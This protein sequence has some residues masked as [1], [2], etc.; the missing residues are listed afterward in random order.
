MAPRLLEL[1]EAFQS[2]L[3]SFDP[4]SVD[5][6]AAVTVT[7]VLD[8]AARSCAKV[9][10]RVGEVLA[11]SRPPLGPVELREVRDQMAEYASRFDAALLTGTQ[12]AAVVDHATAIERMAATTKALAA[13]RVDETGAWEGS[14]D[15]SGAHALARKTGTTVGKARAT[16]ATAKRLS[17]QPALEEAAR[18]GEVSEEQASAI[19]EA[20][21]ANPG[22]EKRLVRQATEERGSLN[23]LRNSC[24]RA[25]AAADGDPDATHR[26]IHAGRFARKRNCADGSGEVLYRS[27]RDE[28]A[29]FWAVVQGFVKEEFKKA[30]SERR[31]ESFDA[32]AA[33]AMLAMAHAAARGATAATAVATAATTAA[34]TA[35]EGGA[36]SA[37][38][39]AEPPEVHPRSP[40]PTKVIVRIDWAALVRGRPVEGEVCEIAGVGP[41]PVSVVRRMVASGDAFLAAVVTKGNDVV[42][43]AHLGRRATAFQVTAME[44]L[45][46]VCSV[47]GCDTT[48]YLEIDHRD[49]WSDTYVTRLP[50]LDPLCGP[51]HH[52]KTYEGWALVGGT[53]K[54]PFVPSDD[55]RHPD[56]AGRPPPDP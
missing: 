5:H 47:E 39:D 29:A 19:S 17:T 23:D 24:D 22:A 25:K 46:M 51:H 9:S 38:S 11:L 36:P 6:Q 14:G 12:A 28:I 56:H 33:D 4:S 21:A 31:R 7:R 18:R 49:G 20:A 45:G 43:V 32:Y 15:L 27:T 16:L 13:A 50:A 30:R 55:S 54:R 10:Q 53:G 3:D 26:R 42:N 8:Q 1:A 40:V 2:A 34:P 37:C 35:A 48:G 41:V 44:W 52:L